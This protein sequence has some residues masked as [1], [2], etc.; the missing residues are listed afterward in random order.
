MTGM[1]GGRGHFGLSDGRPEDQ[2]ISLDGG[3]SGK[4]NPGKYQSLV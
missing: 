4:L 1:T 2:W 3:L